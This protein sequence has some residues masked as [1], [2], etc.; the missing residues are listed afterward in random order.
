MVNFMHLN[1]AIIWTSPCSSGSNLDITGRSSGQ[2]ATR[3]PRVVQLVYSFTYFK[4]YDFLVVS[5]NGSFVSN[6]SLSF[7]FSGW[8]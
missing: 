8:S 3:G 5:S 4:E 2:V 6:L 7:K 1:M